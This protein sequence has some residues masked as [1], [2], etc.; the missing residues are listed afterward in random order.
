MSI[1]G[2]ISKFWVHRKSEYLDF[3]QRDSH[4]LQNGGTL[5][6]WSEEVIGGTAI[7]S[8]VNRDRIGDDDYTFALS[9]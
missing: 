3:F 8:R 5:F 7:P 4:S 1:F 6:I 9:V 2:E